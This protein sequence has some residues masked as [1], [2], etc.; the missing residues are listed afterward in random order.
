MVT[1][2]SKIDVISVAASIYCGPSLQ[3]M[4]PTDEL[5]RKASLTIAAHSSSAEEC[6]AL[7]R[8]LGLRHV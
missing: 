4:R 6:R 7:L 3:A 8:M 5:E 1:I 2:T